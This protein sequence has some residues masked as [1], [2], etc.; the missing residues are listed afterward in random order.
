L[1]W[2]I[3]S[4]NEVLDVLPILNPADPLLAVL[5]GSYYEGPGVLP[6]SINQNL[7]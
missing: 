5:K 2:V 6:T 1:V 4:I 7:D 3:S